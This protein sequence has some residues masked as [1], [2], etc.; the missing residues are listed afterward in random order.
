MTQKLTVAEAARKLPE[1]ID[2][3]KPDEEIVLTQNDRTVARIV[4]ETAPHRR[5]RTPG[6]AK[7]ILKIVSEDEE[8]LDDFREYMP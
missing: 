5:R 6:S 2:A 7:G 1:L 4:P 3:L 8:H